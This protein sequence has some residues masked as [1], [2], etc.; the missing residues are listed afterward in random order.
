MTCPPAV[1]HTQVAPLFPRHHLQPDDDPNRV[2]DLQIWP[3]S[4]RETADTHFLR[5]TAGVKHHLRKMADR[6]EMLTSY[7]HDFGIM[8]KPNPKGRSTSFGASLYGTGGDRASTADRMAS[9]LSPAR[10]AA[11][12]PWDDDDDVRSVKSGRSERQLGGD[13]SGGLPAMSTLSKMQTMSSIGEPMRLTVNGRGDQRWCP[14]THPH[15][16]LGMS[17][18][19]CALVR[20]ANIMNLRAPDVPFSTR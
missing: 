19:R 17:E 15:M 9:S 20:T 1:R 12:R 4:M 2:R 18:R 7:E 11:P 6:S 13:A 16:V 5:R 3:R 14:K 8:T 10:I